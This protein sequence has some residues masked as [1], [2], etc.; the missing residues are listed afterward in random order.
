MDVHHVNRSLHSSSRWNGMHQWHD[1][2]LT[3]PHKWCCQPQHLTWNNKS[4]NI[5]HGWEITSLVFEINNN[6][7]IEPMFCKHFVDLR[8]FR[9]L[10]YLKNLIVT[11]QGFHLSFKKCTMR[12]NAFTPTLNIYKSKLTCTYYNT[13]GLKKCTFPQLF[14][15]ILGK[16]SLTTIHLDGKWRHRFCLITSLLKNGAST[17]DNDSSSLIMNNQILFKLLNLVNIILG[18]KYN[19][20]KKGRNSC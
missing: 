19:I 1:M 5:G 11:W 8:A 16:I 12:T 18:I 10:K 7:S 13:Q 2:H 15:V 4:H 20:T 14:L 9:N 6:P 3:W 17:K